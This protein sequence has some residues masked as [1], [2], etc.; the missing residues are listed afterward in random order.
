MSYQ[1]MKPTKKL[2]KLKNFRYAVKDYLFQK[3]EKDQ[4]FNPIYVNNDYSSAFLDKIKASDPQ[5]VLNVG[6]AEQ[7]MVSIAAGIKNLDMILYIIQ[8]PLLYSS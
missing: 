5:R 2:F 3:I 7:A 8:Y 4:K 1:L 6:I